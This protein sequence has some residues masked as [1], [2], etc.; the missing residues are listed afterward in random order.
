MRENTDFSSQW[1]SLHGAEAPYFYPCDYAIHISRAIEG[2]DGSC[3]RAAGGLRWL[4]LHLLQHRAAEES[5]G[6]GQ[7]LIDLEVIVARRHDEPHRLASRLQRRREVARLPLE[8]RRLQRAVDQ[9][10]RTVDVVEMALRA[11]RLLHLVGEFHILPALGEPH[12]LEIEHAGAT[13]HA[14]YRIARQAEVLAPV[15]GEDHAREMTAGGVAGD[16]DAVRIAAEARRVLADPGDG[17]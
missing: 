10:H 1:Q 15:G 12:R 14:L 6:A 5:V 3:D 9:G 16:V 13:D 8:F 7:R 4:E 2:V 17:T 11:E